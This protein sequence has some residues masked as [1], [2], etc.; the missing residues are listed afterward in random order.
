MQKFSP[1][2][3][4]AANG[5]SS[6]FPSFLCYLR[7][8]SFFF[9]F[10]LWVVVPPPPF[11][12]C[13]GWRAYTAVVCS[14]LVHRTPVCFRAVCSFISY[15]GGTETLRRCRCCCCYACGTRSPRSLDAQWPGAQNRQRQ[16]W[17]GVGQH[18][19]KYRAAL[20][21]ALQVKA[22]SYHHHHHH[23]HTHT[24]THT[25]TPCVSSRY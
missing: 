7:K 20:C 12:L 13:A 14:F 15:C 17:C 25:H 19:G 23:H 22:Q 4:A 11:V 16:W 6:E 2:L 18:W 10:F 8:I 9:S 21:V 3:L 1:L 5:Q 24:H